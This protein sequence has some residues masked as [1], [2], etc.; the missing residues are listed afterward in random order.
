MFGLFNPKP[1]VFRH[2]YLL[3][4]DHQSS[5]N[6]F[7]NAVLNSIAQARIPGLQA[8]RMHFPEGNILSARR[9]YLRL[10][11]E[12]LFFDICSTSFGSSWFYSFRFSVLPL[13]LR[14]WEIAVLLSLI[15][16]IWFVHVAVFGVF[17]SG[18]VFALNLLGIGY[19]LNT[20]VPMGLHDLDAFIMRL[21][22][23]GPF[24][25]IFLRRETWYREDTRIMYC[26]LVNSI[27]REQI[28]EF[29]GAADLS[30]VNIVEQPV[31]EGPGLMGNLWNALTWGPRKMWDTYMPK[32][33]WG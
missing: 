25:E 30:E 2:W 4:P 10:R 18:I 11:R 6:E 21:P 23:L 26:D 27:T 8:S 9:E 17:W 13:R 31:A 19:L 33:P 15:A 32:P 5:T 22:V 29:T 12:R 3:L 7:Y 16:L 28:R 24:Y 1:K 14:L 20:L